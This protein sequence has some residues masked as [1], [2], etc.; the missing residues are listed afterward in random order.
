MVT[1]FA[2]QENEQEYQLIR[3]RVAGGQVP[4]VQFTLRPGGPQVRGEAESLWEKG[5]GTI[6]AQHPEGGSR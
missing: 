2:C 4:P 5:T 6:S 3:R 1:P